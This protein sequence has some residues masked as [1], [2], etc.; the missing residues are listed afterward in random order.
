M[1]N[2]IADLIQRYQ[3]RIDN[4]GGEDATG[5]DGEKRIGDMHADMALSYME[6][7]QFQELQAAAHASGTLTPAEAITV[8]RTLGGESYGGDWPNGTTLAAK[9]AITHLMGELL[10]VRTKQH[11]NN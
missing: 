11:A 4:L 9:I 6:F 2:R 7:F 8:Y 3:Q 10:T 1:G 5:L